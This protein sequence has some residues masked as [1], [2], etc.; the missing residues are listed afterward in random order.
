MKNLPQF[1]SKPH[2]EVRQYILK[3]KGVDIGSDLNWNNTMVWILIGLVSVAGGIGIV[4][5]WQ[6]RQM[7]NEIDA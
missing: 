1:R 4:K 6:Q 2:E 3:T 7:K 5:W